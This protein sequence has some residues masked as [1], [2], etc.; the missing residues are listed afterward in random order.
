MKYGSAFSNADD[1]KRAPG[2]TVD[3]GIRRHR[4]VFDLSVDG[5][6]SEA[7]KIGHLREGTVISSIKMHTGANLSAINFS[8]G[9]ASATAKYAAAQAGP[10]AVT[11]EL[12]LTITAL[13]DDP[14]TAPEEVLLTP[15]GNL[16]SAGTLV[17]DL[18][19]SK[20]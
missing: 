5:G 15:S 16:P 10:N 2:T 3:A 20:R 18:F 8:A 13:D 12:Q 4:N 1:L 11:K 7:L 9:N 17:V 19:V 6:T 14:L